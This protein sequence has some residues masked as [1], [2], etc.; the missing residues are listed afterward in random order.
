MFV[1]GYELKLY[2]VEVNDEELGAIHID[3][4]SVAS[5]TSKIVHTAKNTDDDLPEDIQE[6]FG[7]NK[8]YDLQD[9]KD[10]LAP[11]DIPVAKSFI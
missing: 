11:R 6:F 10:S 5:D 9:I 8:E 3:D 7:M 1:M 2:L 4:A